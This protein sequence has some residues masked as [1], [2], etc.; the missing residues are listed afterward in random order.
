MEE[1]I[2]E[3]SFSRNPESGSVRDVIEEKIPVVFRPPRNKKCN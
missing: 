1:L 2:E 3:Q